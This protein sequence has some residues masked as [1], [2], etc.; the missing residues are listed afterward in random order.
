MEQTDLINRV[1]GLVNKASQSN[2]MGQH[3]EAKQ[4]LVA[5]RNLLVEELAEKPPAEPE[6]K[7]AEKPAEE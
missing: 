7:P 4:H 3:D 2:G 6:E 5:M 1:A